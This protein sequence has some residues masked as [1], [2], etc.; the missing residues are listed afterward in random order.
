MGRPVLVGSV[1]VAGMLLTVA[2]AGSQPA[3]APAAPPVEYATT[4]SPARDGMPAWFIRGSYTLTGPTSVAP[5][6]KVTFLKRTSKRAP[7]PPILVPF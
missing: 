6:G 2:N 3:K 1:A 5:G 4:S 7:A